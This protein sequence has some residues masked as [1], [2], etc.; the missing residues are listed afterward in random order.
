M[1]DTK[2]LHARRESL[3]YAEKTNRRDRNFQAW[4]RVVAKNGNLV[5]RNSKSRDA[6]VSENMRRALE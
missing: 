2:S 5:K 6:R 4:Q 1:I 3:N